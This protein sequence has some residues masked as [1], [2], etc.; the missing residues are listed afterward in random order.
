MSLSVT[1]PWHFHTMNTTEGNVITRFI[2]EFSLEDYIHY[3]SIWPSARN[4]LFAK[5]LS[6]IVQ[7]DE[8]S[9]KKVCSIFNEMYACFI[10][11]EQDKQVTLYLKLVEFMM[12]FSKKQRE[13]PLISTHVL[14]K[15]ER[16]KIKMVTDALKYIHNN[17]AKPISLS[18][19]ANDLGL[20]PSAV[21]EDL[22]AYTGQEFFALLSEIRIRNACVLLGLKT[23]T[24]KYIAQNTGFSSLQTFYRAF[25]ESKGITPEAYRRKHWLESEGKAGYLMYNNKAWDILYYVHKHFDEPLTPE[26]VANAL[27]ISVSQLYKTIKNDLMLSFTDLLQEVRIKYSCGLLRSTSLSVAQIAIEVGFESTRTFSR[28]FMKHMDCTPTQFKER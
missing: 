8:E 1:M 23:P 22:F 4:N 16:S 13:C 25:K 15:T 5:D 17:Y 24:I 26:I 19:V 12:L 9:F 6:P 10:S 21:R 28:A 7:L 3:S 20:S 11:N 27:S 18:Q 14:S 2:C